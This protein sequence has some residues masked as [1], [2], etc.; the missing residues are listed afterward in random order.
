[1]RE[2]FMRQGG[3][4]PGYF[5]RPACNVSEKCMDRG[6]AGNEAN[7]RFVPPAFAG[8]GGRFA[9]S[10]HPRFAPIGSAI[11]LERNARICSQ[12]ISPSSRDPVK[13]PG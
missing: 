4:Q 9:A 2:K 6:F 8:A 3:G 7:I 10:S 11:G 13:H 5:T 1:M 12:I